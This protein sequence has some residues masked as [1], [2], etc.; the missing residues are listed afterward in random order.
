MSTKPDQSKHAEAHHRELYH[1]ARQLRAEARQR[2]VESLVEEWACTYGA[3]RIVCHGLVNYLYAGVPTGG[4]LRAA[5]ANDLLEAFGRADENNQ[6]CL[7]QISCVLCNRVPS[8]IRG[9]YEIVDRWIAIHHILSEEEVSMKH[10]PLEDAQ[11]S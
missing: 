3:P 4:F 10:A 5:L 1:M 11:F 6:V 2:K 9:S 7:F 8:V